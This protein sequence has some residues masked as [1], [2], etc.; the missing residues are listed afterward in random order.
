MLGVYILC[1]LL[2]IFILYLLVN[3]SIYTKY[4][5]TN[6]PWCK[7][8]ELRLRVE[9]VFRHFNISTDIIRPSNDGKSYCHNKRDIFI[10]VY[11]KNGEFHTIADLT[12]ICLHELAHIEC[13]SCEDIHEHSPRFYEK[14]NQIVS[15][16]FKHN[17]MSSENCIFNQSCSITNK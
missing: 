7:I 3:T 14:F 17:I 5:L 13:K 15:V 4:Y 12:E 9:P 8:Y 10:N 1:L 16:A 11:K 2:L 6:D